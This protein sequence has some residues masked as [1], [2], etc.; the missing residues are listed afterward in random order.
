VNSASRFSGPGLGLARPRD[1]GWTRKEVSGR[2]HC[3]YPLPGETRYPSTAAQSWNPLGTA[4]SLNPRISAS[5]MGVSSLGS[6]SHTEAHS[7][8]KDHSGSSVQGSERRSRNIP[9]STARSVRVLLAIDQQLCEGAAL[10]VAPEPS[11]RIGPVEVRQHENVEK[12][13]ASRRR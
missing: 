13:G 8:L 6:R 9:T 4:A 10:W 11:D 1:T 2:S 5:P 12:L 3:P 7:R